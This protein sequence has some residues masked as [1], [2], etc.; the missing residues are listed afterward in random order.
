MHG[1]ANV[2]GFPKPV[3]ALSRRWRSEADMNRHDIR[4]DYCA[5]TW[6]LYVRK[7]ADRPVRRWEPLGRTGSAR[8]AL[9]V[10]T[11]LLTAEPR[12]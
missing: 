1:C 8:T 9:N 4:L 6:A 12:R 11:A 5:G 3:R 2:T 7:G 10:W